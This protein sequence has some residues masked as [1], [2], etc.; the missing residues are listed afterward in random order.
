MFLLACIHISVLRRLFLYPSTLCKGSAEIGSKNARK[1]EGNEQGEFPLSYQF[2]LH[3][4]VETLWLI[5]FKSW[6]GLVGTDIV[7]ESKRKKEVRCNPRRF[8]L[9]IVSIFPFFEGILRVQ[10][11]DGKIASSKLCSYGNSVVNLPTERVAA[12]SN[13]RMDFDSLGPG[14]GHRHIVEKSVGRRDR[15]RNSFETHSILRKLPRQLPPGAISRWMDLLP[16]AIAVSRGRESSS[17]L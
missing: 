13:Y 3:F 12:V 5:H 4:Y 2:Y 17:K 8:S 9:Q 11:H 10:A 7:K 16:V 6:R 14:I 1:L 15:Y